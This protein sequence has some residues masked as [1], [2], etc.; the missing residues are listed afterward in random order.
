MISCNMNMLDERFSFIFIY[1]DVG[2]Y[3][4]KVTAS[5]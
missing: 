5:R 4:L 3:N 1:H 2:Q